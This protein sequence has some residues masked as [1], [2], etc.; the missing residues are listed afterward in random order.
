M[1]FL[2]G[3]G[4]ASSN[5]VSGCLSLNPFLTGQPEYS[6]APISAQILPLISS[7]G[8]TSRHTRPNPSGAGGGVGTSSRVV[9]WQNVDL[10][11]QLLKEKALSSWG[12]LDS[13]SDLPFPAAFAGLTLL[14]SKPQCSV[15]TAGKQVCPSPPSTGKFPFHSLISFTYP[16]IFYI[17]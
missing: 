9:Y 6:Q 16:L 14:S 13:L 4:R 1:L 2:N 12:Y 8:R 5:D 11:F 17:S 7:A 15:T 3:F 10:L